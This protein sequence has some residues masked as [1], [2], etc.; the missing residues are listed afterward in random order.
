MIG[1]RRR[2]C[3]GLQLPGIRSWLVFRTAAD[4]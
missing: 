3:L 1:C 2:V 4:P